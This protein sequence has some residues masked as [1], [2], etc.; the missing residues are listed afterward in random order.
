[1]Q[2]SV[3]LAEPHLLHSARQSHESQVS[4]S[5][6]S[7]HRAEGMSEF[8]LNHPGV[9][10]CAVYVLW[11]MCAGGPP[12]ADFRLLAYFRPLWGGSQL[13][14]SSWRSDDLRTEPTKR[15]VLLSLSP[16]CLLACLPACLLLCPDW[17]TSTAGSAWLKKWCRRTVSSF[18]SLLKYIL[19][20]IS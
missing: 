13:Q 8:L 9:R 16:S 17:G 4:Y 20:L 10:M 1:M 2:S 6:T 5:W 15:L 7:S 11:Y 3:H 14:S 19:D 18:K 12:G